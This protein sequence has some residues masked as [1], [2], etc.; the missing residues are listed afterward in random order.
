MLLIGARLPARANIIPENPL[1]DGPLEARIL[2]LETSR[3]HFLLGIIHLC[4]GE[5]SDELQSSCNNSHYLYLPRLTA[6]NP[7]SSYVSTLRNKEKTARLS[8]GGFLQVRRPLSVFIAF[9]TPSRTP[10]QPTPIH[11]SQCWR[12]KL[13]FDLSEKK[14]E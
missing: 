6:Y 1:S 4:H 5:N 3:A 11:H 9:E 12:G 13:L 8:A 7:A 14:R 2:R 10:P